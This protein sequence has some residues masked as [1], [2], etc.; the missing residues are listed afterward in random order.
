MNNGRFAK[1]VLS[2]LMMIS[3]L[4]CGCRAE[5]EAGDAQAGQAASL[6]A[7]IAEKLEQAEDEVGTGGGYRICF[8]VPLR[9]ELNKNR[10]RGVCRSTALLL[11]AK[12]AG[13]TLL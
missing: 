2:F 10:S 5:K 4:F 8:R 7:S 9:R 6:P 3:C 11:P 13:Y 1:Y 12:P